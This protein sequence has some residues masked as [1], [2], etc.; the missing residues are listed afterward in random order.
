[1]NVYLSKYPTG[2]IID[3]KDNEKNGEK[4]MNSGKNELLEK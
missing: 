2:L 4:E 1:M 3:G